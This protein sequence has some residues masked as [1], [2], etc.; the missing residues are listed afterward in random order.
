MY[1]YETKTLY[2]DEQVE[3]LMEN[4]LKYYFEWNKEETK[5]SPDSLENI[6]F[7]YVDNVFNRE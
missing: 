7:K 5:Y 4:F 1:D 2:G 3:F 6:P